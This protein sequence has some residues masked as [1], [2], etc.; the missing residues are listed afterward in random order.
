MMQDYPKLLENCDRVGVTQYEK[1]FAFSPCKNDLKAAADRSSKN[2]PADC[3]G[4]CEEDFYKQG[5][6]V[7]ERC[8]VQIE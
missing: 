5:I 2:L 8:G 7:L 6:L 4:T 3:C 1:L